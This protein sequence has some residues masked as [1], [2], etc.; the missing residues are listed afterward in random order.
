[1]KTIC[2]FHFELSQNL[3]QL[4]IKFLIIPLVKREAKDF[5]NQQTFCKNTKLHEQIQMVKTNLPYTSS[6]SIFKSNLIIPLKE[7]YK[8]FSSC[9]VIF[10]TYTF[11]E[12][13]ASLPFSTPDGPPYF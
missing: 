9:C 11:F 13:L 4:N 12:S 2:C 10:L 7:S 5:C 6:C 1:M 8:N 3:K